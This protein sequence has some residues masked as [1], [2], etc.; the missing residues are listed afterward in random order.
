MDNRE[1]MLTTLRRKKP[2]H[3]PFGFSLC[4]SL[5]EEFKLRTGCDDYVEYYDMDYRMINLKP[6]GYPNDYSSYHPDLPDN[7]FIDEW[8]V[9]YIPGSLAHFTRFVSPMSDYDS[10][11]QVWAF[12]S[13]DLDADYRFESLA[14]DVKKIQNAGYA[15]VYSAVQLFEPAWYLRGLDNFLSDMIIDEKMVEA[16]M[17][18]VTGIME[19][20][21]I[22]LAGANVDCIM[23]G[24]DAGTQKSLMMSMDLWRKWIKPYTKR[25]IDIARKIKPDLIVCYHSDGVIYDLI[26][27]LIDIG[28]D[29]LNPVQPECIDPVVIKRLYGDKLAFWGTIGTQT[30]MPFGTPEEVRRVVNERIE[31]VG[32]DGG[33]LIAPTHLLEPEVPWEN[34]EA[35]VDAVKAYR[36]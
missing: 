14:E 20:V 12:P 27:D 16:A 24:D 28:V 30:T 36:Y 26:P 18:K 7:G 10:P 5:Y 34:I 17:E 4:D 15:A 9:G 6:S 33:L 11:E 31:T 25:V 22:K 2:S 1:N 23:Y 8:G 13:P 29:V 32:Y 35:L 3:V 19:S 21:C